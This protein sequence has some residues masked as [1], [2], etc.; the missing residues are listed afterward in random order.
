VYLK[1]SVATVLIVKQR[2]LDKV[3]GP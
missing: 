3:V 1:A 2:F